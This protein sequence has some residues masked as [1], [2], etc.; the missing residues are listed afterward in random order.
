MNLYR[1]VFGCMES[2]KV[3]DIVAPQYLILYKGTDPVLII[4]ELLLNG[5]SWVYE[6]MNKQIS[7]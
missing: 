4:S 5:V 7:E 1:M 6:Y 2:R 3:A